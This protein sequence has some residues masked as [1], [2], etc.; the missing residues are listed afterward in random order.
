MG[1]T[2]DIAC[3]PL[4]FVHI[5]VSACL[6]YS[7][8]D[9]GYILP[10]Y[11]NNVHMYMYTQLLGLHCIFEFIRTYKKKQ[12]QSTK[13]NIYREIPLYLQ[14]SHKNV[15]RAMPSFH[16]FFCSIDIVHSVFSE[17]CVFSF[18]FFRLQFYR[19]QKKICIFNLSLITQIFPVIEEQLLIMIIS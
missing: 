8:I 19:F 1:Y 16:L 9:K 7:E 18:V 17:F 3:G 15:L 14:T 4:S 2:K 6:Q 10:R 11:N 13:K 12:K 5:S